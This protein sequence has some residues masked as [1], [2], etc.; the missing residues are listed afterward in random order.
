MAIRD[1]IA[2]GVFLAVMGC[3]VFFLGTFALRSRYAAEPETKGEPAAVLGMA[4]QFG[5]YLA[6]WLPPLQRPKFSAIVAMPRFVEW[7][8]AAMTIATAAAS[9]W[10]VD[11]ASRQLGK[12]W[13]LA[14]RLVEG[15]DLITDGPYAWV[16]NPIYLGMLGL[17]VATGLTLSRW[18]VLIAATV[19]FL[20]GTVIRIRSEE[21][22]LKSAF[23]VAFPAYTAKVAAL[24]PGIY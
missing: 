19:V 22:L 18:R 6:V 8:V 5:C 21:R 1:P 7:S 15:H 11:T 14:A 10:L 12:Q 4:L 24:I 13:G 9:V 17:M 2:E 23:G 20:I 16:R 3:W